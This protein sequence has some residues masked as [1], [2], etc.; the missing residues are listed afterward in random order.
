MPGQPA[1]GAGAGQRS[2]REQ[3]QDHLQCLGECPGKGEGG[4]GREGDGRRGERGRELGMEGGGKEEGR[5]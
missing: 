3:A 2:F 4:G 5:E 1:E